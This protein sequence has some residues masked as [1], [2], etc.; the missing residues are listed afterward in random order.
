MLFRSIDATPTTTTTRWT[1]SG[2][3]PPPPPM[4]VDGPIPRLRDTFMKLDAATAGL[5]HTAEGLAHHLYSQPGN[6]MDV[7]SK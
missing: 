2:V 6:T 7:A 1:A 4:D 5:E 3:S